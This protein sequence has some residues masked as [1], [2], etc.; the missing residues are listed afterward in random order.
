MSEQEYENLWHYSEQFSR[1]PLQRSELLTMAYVQGKKKMGDKVTPGMMK[2]VMH[3]RSK[4]LKSRSA[5]D[6]HEV[7]KSKIDA[8]NHERV[9]VDRP[10]PGNG[11]TTS[12]SDFLLPMRITPLDFAQAEDFMSALTD[13]ERTFLDDLTAGYTLKEISQRQHIQYTRLPAL[14][15]SLQEKA[16]AYL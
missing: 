10:L 15:L 3:Y 9:Y 6:L 11:C 7:G 16:V 5:F 2:S 12:L 1:D 13:E 14:R 4:E 8:W